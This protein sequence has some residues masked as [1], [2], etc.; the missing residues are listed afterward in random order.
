MMSVTGG[1]DAEASE[2]IAF[3]DGDS[4]SFDIESLDI[5]ISKRAYAALAVTWT[6]SVADRS[7]RLGKYSGAIPDGW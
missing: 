3:S 4:G 7:G 6:L 5:M 2:P 1:G